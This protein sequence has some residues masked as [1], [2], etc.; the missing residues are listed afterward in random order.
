MTAMNAENKPSF[1]I[2]D[3]YRATFGKP[4]EG[5]ESNRRMR[6]ALVD[7]RRFIL[8]EAMS[9]F[10]ADVAFA[11]VSKRTRD[12]SLRALDFA[13]RCARLPHDVTWIEFDVP[14]FDARE[15]ELCGERLNYDPPDGDEHFREGWLLNG[16]RQSEQEFRAHLFRSITRGGVP[17]VLA[18]PFAVNWRTDDGAAS[19]FEI[20]AMTEKS[21][22]TF[23]ADAV[24]GTTGWGVRSQ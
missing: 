11:V 7:A 21:S 20:D 3:M 17:A 19:Y 23:L 2:D 24:L 18:C 1:L 13:R 5:W 6:R 14:K 9:A 4:V 16:F 8:D 15:I 22:Q 10:L 12:I